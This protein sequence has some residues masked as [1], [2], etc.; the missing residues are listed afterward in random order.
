M[1]LVLTDI[2]LN[3]EHDLPA[4]RS[5]VNMILKQNSTDSAALYYMGMIQK[6]EGDVNGAIQNLSKAWPEIR[7]APTLRAR[8]VPLPA[9]RDLTKAIPAL[10]QA[11]LL[12]PDEAQNHYQLALAYSRTG[13]S[14]KAKAQL[15]IYQQMKAKE[16]RDAKNYKGPSTSEV[17]SMGIGSKP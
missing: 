12:A 4:A 14:D 1:N 11:V 15:G 6:M 3:D 9:S 5:R 7:K 2:A 17:P 8:S 16:V 13:V 10:E